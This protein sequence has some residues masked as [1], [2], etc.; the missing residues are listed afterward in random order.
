M[1]HRPRSRRSATKTLISPAGTATGIPSPVCSDADER[2]HG[3][4]RSGDGPLRRPG[5]RER[6]FYWSFRESSE[7]DRMGGRDFP[8]RTSCVN[9][10]PRLE[11]FYRGRPLLSVSFSSL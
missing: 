8:G 2:R 4:Y 7:T 6:N 9:P 11:G 10:P 5:I 1:S 3:I